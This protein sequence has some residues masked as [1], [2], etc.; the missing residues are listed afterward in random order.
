MGQIK[1]I[2]GKLRTLFQKLSDVKPKSQEDYL[3]VGAWLVSRKLALLLIL[4]AC[5]L[6]GSYIWMVKPQ[7]VGGESPYKTYKYNS[8]A[9]KLQTD[10][11]CI[12]GKSGYKAY[13]GQIQEGVITGIGTLYRKDGT[14]AYAG[15]FSGNAYNG[16]GKRYYESE[17]LWYEGTFSDNEFDGEGSLYRE[18][19]TLQYEGEFLRG[20]MEGAGVLYDGG[21]N[22][23][24]T[25]SFQKNEIRYEELLGKTASQTAQ[26]Y[27]GERRVYE[28]EEDYCVVMPD[29]NAAYYS[30][31]GDASL[32]GEW[33]TKGVYVFKDY[34]YI[35]GVK[36][37]D[38]QEVRA[39]LGEPEYEG[40]TNVSGNDAVAV[41]EAYSLMDIGDILYGKVEMSTTPLFE[42][43]IRV[44]SYD[45]GYLVYIY[46]FQTKDRTYTFY[47]GEKEKEFAFYLL[48]E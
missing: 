46:V 18:N 28:S 33:M 27:T 37:Q 31:S 16:Q 17:N 36:V 32:D 23:V 1:G 15:E 42:E 8:P 24:Y 2:F 47:C 25:G 11:V 26:M 4:G 30:V 29:I 14:V 35:N 41:N 48:E 9:L 43:V 44:D 19:G 10:T 5:V 20:Y 34:L 13:V 38:I 39:L 12:L 22:P 6:C 45:T 21:E 7:S 40:N 3:T